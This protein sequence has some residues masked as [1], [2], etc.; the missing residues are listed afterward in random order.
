MSGVLSRPLSLSDAPPWLR[1]LAPLLPALV[2][3][4]SLLGLHAGTTPDSLRY[5]AAAESLRATGS[6]GAD[7][8]LWPPLYPA[9]LALTRDPV[10]FAAVLGDLG[11][12]ATVLGVWMIGRRWLASP[13]TLALVLLALVAVDR[14]GGLFAMVWSETVFI[15]LVVWLAY[16][17]GRFFDEGRGLVPACALLALA[18]LTR[19]VGVVLA[20]AMALTAVRF[21]RWRALGG[22]ALAC[23]PYALWLWRTYALCGS[24]MGP[25]SPLA[26]PNLPRQVD[27]FGEVW[28]HWLWPHAYAGGTVLA[29]VVLAAFLGALVTLRRS[30]WWTFASLVLLGHCVLTVYSASRLVLDVDART[31]FPALWLALLLA[32][33]A[34]ERAVAG[35]RW[36]QVLLGLYLFAW[37][38]A[39]NAIINA[40]V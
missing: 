40:L 17:W 1:T 5:L 20:I 32:G 31:L 11:A 6:L 15:P 22:I 18:L 16:Y 38:V 35:R 24:P 28:G 14:F 21:G 4:V 33:F 30:P 3:L 39:P 12:L 29:F 27:L 8:L 13:V 23:A 9:L 19:H 37:F 36:A 7:F 2:V 26:H 25:R 34:A 10:T